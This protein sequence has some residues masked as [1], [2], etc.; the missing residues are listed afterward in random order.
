MDTER[1]YS[2]VEKALTARHAFMLDRDY[3]V[4]DDKITIVDES[5]GRIMDGR[6]WQDGLHQAIEAKELVPITA[7]TG[8]AARITVQSFFRNYT[9]LAGMTGTA[10]PA[11]RELKKTYRLK[12][13]KIPTNKKCLRQGLKTL[14][15]TDQE[16]KRDAI[17][18]EIES[19]L[20]AGRAILVGTPSVDSSEALGKLLEDRD[21]QHTILNAKYHE[22]EADIVKQA[23]QPGRV[24]IAT[25]MAGRGTD[26][27]LTDDVKRNG[28][29][30]V[31]ATE[32]HSSKRIDRQLIGRSARQGDQGSYQ[33]FLSL[34]DELLRVLP[35]RKV[36]RKRRSARGNRAGRLSGR[37]QGF[38]KRTQ[39]TIEKSHYKQRKQL[40][41]AEKFRAEAYE[42]MGLD[43]YLE[44]TES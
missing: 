13:A 7:A 32:Y 35:D 37:W 44:L 43:P 42:R 21:I 22:M 40:L 9:N 12:V 8:Q 4:V 28:G 24:T 11:R 19:M 23:G 17:V 34:E 38:F 16:K 31:I 5:T 33:F 2:Q 6:K 3:V 39:K 15:Y 18:N 25:N 41:K 36:A 20:S 30:H 10:M 27:I 26:I 29:L 14:V 1:I